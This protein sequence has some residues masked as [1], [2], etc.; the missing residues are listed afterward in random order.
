M[1]I[2]KLLSVLVLAIASLAALPSNA[3]ESPDTASAAY[4]R[5]DYD[6]AY[7]RALPA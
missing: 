5:K 3:A 1:H 7:Q 6:V 2:A 4:Q